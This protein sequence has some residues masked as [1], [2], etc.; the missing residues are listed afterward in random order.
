MHARG[1]CKS[2]G[3][4]QV[5]KSVDFDLHEGEVVLL[6]GDN[7]SGKTTLLNIL[8][9]N[10]E[11]EAGLV[12]LDAD[13]SAENFD[14]P[15]ACWRDLNPFDH[16]TPERV[17]NE[18]A[19][20]T[21]QDIRLFST[22]TLADNI[23]VATPRQ[24]GESPLR[25]IFQRRLIRRAEDKNRTE[26]VKLLSGLG[27]EQRADS[28]ADKISLGQTKRVAIARAVRAGARVLFLDEPLAGLDAKGIEEVMTLLTD[29]AHNDK[30]TLVI[31]EHVFNIPRVLDLAHTVWTL[32][33]GCI[34]SE[35]PEKVRNEMRETA[36]DGVMHLLRSVAGAPTE[37]EFQLPG[38]A[39]LT[40][41]QRGDVENPKDILEIKDL[42]VRRGNRLV[43]GEELADGKI[44]GLSLTLYAG[45]LAVLQA[46]N[47]WGKTT[48]LE[49]LCGL[50]PIERGEIR[51]QGRPIQALPPWERIKLGFSVL[52]A[53]NH[54]FDNL[55]VAE[56]FALAG[57]EQ[58]PSGLEPFSTRDGSSL[59]GGEAQRVVITSLNSK[60][61]LG[62]YDEPFSALDGASF[63]KTMEK[64]FLLAKTYVSLILLPKTFRLEIAGAFEDG[65]NVGVE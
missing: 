19:G 29:L 1:L 22:Q 10:L 25:A 56:T 4:N 54:H 27:L 8:T 62:L 45:D 14:F 32:R 47:G 7:G 36:G 41:L 12:S 6:R 53:R 2:F 24:P 38:G 40:R 17:A 13:G 59:S 63:K 50:I 64:E 37:Q 9:G 43:I 42:V 5:L 44:T 65:L 26:S 48:L 18:A 51:F 58:T 34:T 21:W 31:I 60:A 11:P 35:T 55:T 30:V 52:Q 3:G 46:P 23:A 28:S 20:R 15:R 39:I 16:F 57:Q 33:D 61:M 49:A